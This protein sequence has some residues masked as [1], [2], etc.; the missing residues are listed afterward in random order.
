METKVKSRKTSDAARKPNLRERVY[1]IVR[2][3]I[4]M[5]LIRLED[6]L[7]DHDIAQELHVSRMPVREALMQLKNEGVLEGTARGFVLRRFTLA[8]MNEIFEIRTLL[9]PSAAASASL[10]ADPKSLADMKA[11]LEQAESAHLRT[12]LDDFM[13]S[14]ARFRLV[15]LAMVPNRELAGAI[16]RYIDHVQVVRLVTMDDQEVRSIILDGMRGLYE[17][18]L[19][20]DTELVRVRMLGHARAAAACY[21]SAYQKIFESGPARKTE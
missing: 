9:E 10:H 20:G 18:F 14:N 5:G 19:S 21:Y 11:A 16:S 13:R 2:Q 7:V 1:G 3:R 12:D 6:R 17:A 8:E 4:Q 15:W